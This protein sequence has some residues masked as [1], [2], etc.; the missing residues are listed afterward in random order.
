MAKITLKIFPSECAGLISY[1]HT[2]K[3]VQQL[4]LTQRTVSQLVII[5]YAKTW[6]MERILSWGGKS[7][8]KE[9][10]VSMPVAVAKALHEDMQRDCLSPFQRSFLGKLDQA[11][12][13]YQS[14]SLLNVEVGTVTGWV[15][16][17]TQNLKQPGRLIE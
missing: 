14:G 1:L 4:P 16:E 12:I 11:I 5:Q 6:N 7:A 17:A 10:A 3:G 15:Y 8:Q 9:Y 13:N 2:F